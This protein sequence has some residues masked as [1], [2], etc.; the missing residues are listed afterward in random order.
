MDSSWWNF[1]PRVGFAYRL[2]QDGKTSIRGG[3]GFYYTPIET[4]DFN[5]FSNIAPFAPT[6]RFNDVA[7][8]DP[9]RS[10]GVANPFPAQFGPTVRGPDVDFT[11]PAAVRWTFAKN[12]R[13]PQITTWNLILERQVGSGWV[14]KAIYQAS[15]GTYLSQAIVRE[16]NPAIYI[17]GQSTVANT[18]ARRQ[19]QD[20]VNVGRIESGN[21]SHYNALQLNAEKRFAH[22]LSILANYT[23]SRAMDDLG[24]S[25]P[26]YRSFDYAPAGTDLP[27][28][29]KFSNVWEV[30]RIGVHGPAGLLLNGWMLNSMVVWQSGFPMTISSGRDNSFSGVGRDRADFLGGTADLG[31]GR[32]H[33]DMVARFFDTSKFTANALGTFGNSGRDN[34]RGPRFFNT[35]LSVVKNT[36]ITE[37]VSLQFRAEFFNVFNNV[38][39]RPPTT[40]AASAQFG[41]ISA[42]ADP[43]ILQFALKLIF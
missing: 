24:W 33:G 26:Y 15:K 29:F 5:A 2:T 38:N 21:N 36:K 37:R 40:N 11:L 4:T 7:F 41:R 17:P 23:Y 8:E 30:P 20:F 42:A 31:S 43:R 28:N 13:I 6:F 10:A 12:F 35:D 9:Y 25:N 14:L 34:L 19:Y 22:G 27:H 3:V 1:A 16:V 18:Q 39:F 32:P